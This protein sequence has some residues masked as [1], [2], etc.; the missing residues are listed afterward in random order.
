M[1][2]SLHLVHIGSPLA[3]GVRRAVGKDEAIHHLSGV[4]S[5]VDVDVTSKRAIAWVSVGVG[6]CPSGVWGVGGTTS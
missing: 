4:V 6:C 5:I 1:I 3:V 2:E